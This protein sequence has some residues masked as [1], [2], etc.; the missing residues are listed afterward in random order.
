[1]YCHL[2]WWHKS[3]IEAALWFKNDYPEKY[4]KIIKMM[5]P[6]V[7][8]KFPKRTPDELLALKLKLEND[9]KG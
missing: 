2:H 4:K 5:N 7:Y 3:P 9:A 8:K 6:E 1:M